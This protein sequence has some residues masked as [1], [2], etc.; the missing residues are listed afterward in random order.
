MSLLERV[1]NYTAGAL[2]TAGR[3]VA[4]PVAAGVMAL[5]PAPAQAEEA[6]T[7]LYADIMV[8]E[9]LHSDVMVSVDHRDLEAAVQHITDDDYDTHATILGL[10]TPEFHGLRLRQTGMIEYGEDSETNGSFNTSAFY[11]IPDTDLRLSVGGGGAFPSNDWMVRG[12]LGYFD[13]VLNAAFEVLHHESSGQ[14]LDFRGY[15]GFLLDNG[16]YL[17]V[18]KGEGTNLYNSIGYIGGP[19]EFNAFIRNWLDYS[20]MSSKHSAQFTWNSTRGR[21]TWEFHNQ[22]QTGTDGLRD[23]LTTWDP[24]LGRAPFLVNY[25]EYGL[26]FTFAQ[27]PEGLGGSAQF[28]YNPGTDF[29]HGFLQ[30]TVG[31]R[32]NYNA[33]DDTTLTMDTGVDIDPAL[34][35]I[36]VTAHIPSGE[37]DGWAYAGFDFDL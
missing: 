34:I 19:G 33:D 15:A 29:A 4:G 21:G 14:D 18:G 30:L 11:S 12:G 17:S 25:G 3:Y 26:L 5:T 24:T 28:G 9:D 37:F 7:S 20:D 35:G 2:R 16:F 36:G 1:K 23:F 31:H 10:N 22:F 8:T 13:E 27:D 6:N 32:H